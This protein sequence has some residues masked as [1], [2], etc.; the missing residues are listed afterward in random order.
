MDLV[1]PALVPSMT[2][3]TQGFS[4]RPCN[5]LQVTQSIAGKD[6]RSF[7]APAGTGQ[8]AR[9]RRCPPLPGTPHTAHPAAAS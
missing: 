3:N 9:G 8:R 2:S 4:T 6:Q 5:A 1:M 7:F